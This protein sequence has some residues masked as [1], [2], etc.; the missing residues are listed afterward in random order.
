MSLSLSQAFSTM[1]NTV[2]FLSADLHHRYYAV[3]DEWRHDAAERYG[4]DYFV[5]KTLGTAATSK[6]PVVYE[7]KLFVIHSARPRSDPDE[8]AR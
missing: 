7:N 1:Q 2:G 3:S 8:P 5:S 4:I 6:L